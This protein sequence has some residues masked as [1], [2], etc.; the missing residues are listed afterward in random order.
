MATAAASQILT[1]TICEGVQRQQGYQARQH[2]HHDSGG[3]LLATTDAGDSADDPR[4]GTR[5]HANV[6]SLV[7]HEQAEVTADVAR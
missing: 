4:H 5:E 7:G 1:R 6:T 3:D 2:D